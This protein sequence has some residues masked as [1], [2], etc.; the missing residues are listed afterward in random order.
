MVSEL[1]RVFSATTA[2]E[3]S[4]LRYAEMSTPLFELVAPIR[5]APGRMYRL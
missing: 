2:V 5:T 1:P 4:V 3:P